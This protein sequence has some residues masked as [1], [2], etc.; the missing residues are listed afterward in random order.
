MR[1][2]PGDLRHP[3]RSR[4]RCSL[5]G[6]A[7]FAGPRCTEPE[8]P[9]SGSNCFPCRKRSLSHSVREE[10]RREFFRRNVSESLTINRAGRAPI[11]LAMVRDGKCF[12]RAVA[13]H[14][15]QLDVT[16]SLRNNSKSKQAENADYFGAGKSLRPRHV[17]EPSLPARSSPGWTHP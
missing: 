6:L 16:A 13:Q 11:Q 17:P 1:G 9:R 3:R 2:T 14:T 5:P 4:Y 12:S 10:M 15:S 7:G 8:V